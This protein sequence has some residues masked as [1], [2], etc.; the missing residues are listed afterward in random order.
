M[1]HQFEVDF[2]APPR[3]ALLVDPA[4]PLPPVAPSRA[5]VGPPRPPEPPP[6][7]PPPPPEV[8]WETEIGKQL[9]QDR[10]AINASLARLGEQLRSLQEQRENSWRQWQQAAIELG[11]AIASRLVHARIE[12]GGMALETV[13]REAAARLAPDEPLRVRLH[14]RDLAVL[15]DRLKGDPLLPEALMVQIIADAS[16]KR[17]DC[18]VEGRDGDVLSEVRTQLADLR[19]DLLGRLT[20]AGSQT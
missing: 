19:S 16:L 10:A 3:G 4:E 7:P 15:R 18:H 9:S 8:F 13:V 12:T 2:P 1:R 14:P 11:L 20:H 5:I 17:G 6:P